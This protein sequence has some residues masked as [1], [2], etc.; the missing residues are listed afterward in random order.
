MIDQHSLGKWWLLGLA[1]GLWLPATSA[2]TAAPALQ[3][4]VPLVQQFLSWL[5]N[6][7]VA[8]FLFVLGLLGLVGELTLPG[9]IFPGVTGTICL[10]LA[11]V[12]LGQLPTNWGGA[13]LILA[14]IAMFL[15]D[16]K[17]P[18]H[19][20][21]IGGVVAFGLGSLLL[22]T[23][24]WLLPP[25]GTETVSVSLSP[26]LILIMTVSVASLFVFGAA[27]GLQAQYRPL[28][29]GRETLLGQVGTVRQALEPAGI[30]HV[31]GEEWSA[32]SADGKP[33]AAGTRVQVVGTDGLTLR[34]EPMVD[35]LLGDRTLL[36]GI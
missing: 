21:S 16:I 29:M 30:V 20:L 2:W 31:E 28:A 9:A 4:A 11:L 6:P 7:N 5:A 26:W 18:G 36:D 12:G 17:V 13:G 3:P 27:A 32:I 19:G 35:D 8:Y 15:L 1:A 34:V 24:F 22:F 23:P 33:I 25:T 14:A 10:L